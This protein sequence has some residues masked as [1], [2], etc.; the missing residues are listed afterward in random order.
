[1][2]VIQPSLS[3]RAKRMNRADSVSH[4][5]SNYANQIFAEPTCYAT[6]KGAELSRGE[7]QQ[8]NK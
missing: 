3:T 5:P 8:L 6:L 7:Y 1:M 2:Q 4:P